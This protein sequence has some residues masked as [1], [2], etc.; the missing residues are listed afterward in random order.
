MSVQ[1]LKRRVAQIEAERARQ[2][3]YVVV[4][5]F[6]TAEADADALVRVEAARLEADR[7][8]KTLQVIRIGWS[9][10]EPCTG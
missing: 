10:Q 9:P 7:Q 4:V 1:S 3:E 2:S 6:G 8:G 5:F